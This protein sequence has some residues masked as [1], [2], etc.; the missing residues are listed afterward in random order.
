MKIGLIQTRGLGDILIALPI[1]SYFVDQGHEIY[2]PID[3]RFIKH[4][5]K[6]FPNVNFLKVNVE[7]IVENTLEYFYSEPHRILKEINCDEIFNLYSYLSGQEISNTRYSESLNF[8][9]Y[10]YAVCGVPF[11]EKWKLSP[12]R[13]MERELDL[14]K[15]LGLNKNE[16][17]IAIHEEGSNF[18]TDF[19]ELVRN[20]DLKKVYIEPKTDCLFDWLTV[21][22]NAKMIICIDS[23]F[24]NLIE[25]MNL[26]NTKILYLRSRVNFTP[27]FRNKW[28]IK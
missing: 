3:S 14:F 16:D 23:V 26:V 13:S 7:E 8:D 12:V 18:K 22:E 21:I 4:F 11:D 28:L 17:Y 19:T 9:A 20:L 24:S 5:E 10:K 1:A 6:T 2:W 15:N 27:V 25:Q